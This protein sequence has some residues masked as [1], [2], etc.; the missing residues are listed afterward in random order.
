MFCSCNSSLG[1]LGNPSCDTLQSVTKKI[2]YVP[3]Y[4][5]LGVRNAILKTDILNESYVSAKINHADES[6]RWYPSPTIE[7]VEDTKAEAIF[8]SLNSGANIFIQEGVRTFTGVH[9]KQSATFLGKLKSGKCVSFGVYLIDNDGNL[10]GSISTDGTKLYPIM[11]DKDTF[12]PTLIKATD[13][14]VAKVQV[15][16]EFS[17]I[18]RDENLK[19]ITANDFVGVDLLSL[20]GLL[21]G[22]VA[23]SDDT[24]TSVTATITTSYGSFTSPIKIEGL[25]LADFT[26]FN[27]T[28]NAAVTITS[29]T[30]TS[31][32]VYVLEF[33]AQSAADS[34][35]LTVAKTGFSVEVATWTI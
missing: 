9:V 17:R 25:L 22:Y 30:E 12:Q 34:M 1:N 35:R 10:T 14:T 20:N 27:V 5:S 32:G 18:E 11:V 4:N 21:D 28:D 19:M 7:N 26:L 24:T 29:V 15:S 2:I 16:F 8:E 3:I 31:A 33:A 13:T 23:I 6:V